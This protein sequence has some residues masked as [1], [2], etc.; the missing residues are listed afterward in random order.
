MKAAIIIAC[1]LMA[2]CSREAKEWSVAPETYKCTEEQMTRVQSETK[3]CSENTSYRESYC[4]GAAILR[5]CEP[6]E[7]E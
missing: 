6:P 3:W 2:A 5:I 7:E 1:M 4:Y